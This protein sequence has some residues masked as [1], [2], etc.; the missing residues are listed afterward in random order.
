P[1]KS[2]IQERFVAAQQQYSYLTTQAD[3]LQKFPRTTDS[4]G[5][6]IGTS[7]WDWTGG[8]FPGSLWF[9][10]NQTAD[11]QTKEAAIRWTEKLEAAKNL[12]QHHDIGFVMYCSYGNAIKYLNDPKK[13]E[14]YKAIVIHS[15]NTALKR[16][17]AKVGL[18]KSWNQKES[19]DG[20]T[21]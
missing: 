11:T 7:E 21:L 19:W 8:F 1:E 12:D 17:D 18:I 4:L 20:K 15:A 5:A 13:V 9:I 14:A 2:D 16:Y 6:L 10:Y 3:S